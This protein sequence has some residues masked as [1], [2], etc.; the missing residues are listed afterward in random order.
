MKWPS[1]RIALSAPKSFGMYEKSVRLYP[2][3]ASMIH[4]EVGR[5]DFDT[6]A[7]I[8]QATKDALDAGRVHYGEF[9][10]E[11]DLREVIAQRMNQV[12]QIPVTAQE[13]LVTNG[14]THASFA[15]MLAAIDPGDEVILLE[16]YYPQ[17]INKIQLAGGVV[18]TV[19]LN[20]AGGFSIDVQ[21]LEAAIT[22]RTRMICLVNPNNPTG[23]V[24]SRAELEGLARVAIQHDLLVC[25]DEVYERIVFDGAQHISIASLPGMAERT[26]S[27]FAFTKA[28]AMDGWRMGWVVAAPRFMPALM[29]ITMND[30]SHVNTFIQAGGVAALMG[31]QAPVQ[32]MV[33]ED[34]RRRD[35]VCQQLNAM[36]GV[37]CTVP[38]STIY[39]WADIR[40]T[41]HTSQALAD[42][43]LERVQVVV[44]SGAFYGPAG[45]GYIRICF[46]GESYE[47]LHEA[48]QRMATVIT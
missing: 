23:R 1:D 41:G 38:T 25:S 32:A 40:G 29:K 14:L 47:R 28:Y 15:V 18:V 45:E 30:V 43:L 24:Y 39:A 31:D 34:R 4:L 8:K 17:V 7:H 42:L 46:G 48:M 35:M 21:A 11:T 33:D 37:R 9:A 12:N 10:G 26:F 27:L 6:P 19:P 44:E 13:V 3:C 16:P 20:A 36:P 22:P 5:P 2:Q